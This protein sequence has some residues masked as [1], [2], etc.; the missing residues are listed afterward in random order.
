MG[1]REGDR[2]YQAW[3]TIRGMI[4]RLQWKAKYVELIRASQAVCTQDPPRLS[5]LLVM[6]RKCFSQFVIKMYSHW[7]GVRRDEDCA[8]EMLIM[9]S[10]LFPAQAQHTWLTGCGL[11]GE[12]LCQSDTGSVTGLWPL[13]VEAVNNKV[14]IMARSSGN[15]SG[16]KH[17]SCLIECHCWTNTV[18]RPT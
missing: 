2:E 16:H 3:K 17:S 7:P 11:R 4:R 9:L 12:T 15:C 13:V 8:I 5:H 14:M 6:F 1:G 10:Q 18:I